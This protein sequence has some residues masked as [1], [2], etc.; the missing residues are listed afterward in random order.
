MERRPG[1]MMSE[2]IPPKLGARLSACTSTL[3]ANPGSCALFL[4][5][6]GTLLELAPTPKSV[7]VPE[8]LLGLLNR[9]QL[10]F[11]GAVAIVT[12]RLITEADQ[13]LAPLRFA[14]SGVHGAELRTEPEGDIERVSPLLP[15]EVAHDLHRLAE[16][17][18]GVIAEPKG[19]GLAL[20]YRLAPHAQGDL[21]AALE[22]Y[23]DS[24]AAG[25]LELISGKRLFEVIPSGL[26]KG[27]ALAALSALA[28][29]RGRRPI[30]IGDDIGD[31]SA[32]AAAEGMDGFG[33]RVAGEHYREDVADFA[34][35]KAVIAWLDHVARR[36]QIPAD[37]RVGA[38][39]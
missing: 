25:T 16:R 23:L 29:F 39:G 21:L 13:I 1:A 28:T 22:T 15:D 4:D 36:L 31:E 5:M 18:P 8:G 14:A 10:A 7:R 3:L 26:S 2:T 35:P 6:D 24:H 33:L 32:F 38:E 27:T 20:H 37:A 34:G 12:G 11:G 19:P 30:M 17:F 9:L